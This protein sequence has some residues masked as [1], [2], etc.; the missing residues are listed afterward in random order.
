MRDFKRHNLD[1]APEGSQNI[2]E[3]VKDEYGF[4][5]NIMGEFAE[6]PQALRAYTRLDEIFSDT[7]FNPVEQ[8]II[9]LSASVAN[10]CEYCVAVHSTVAEQKQMPK[11][12]VNRIRDNETLSDDRYEALRRFTDR[13][14]R[15]RGRIAED[16][17]QD[18]LDAGFSRRQVLEL[19]VGV[20]MKTL[21][22]Y[23]N[24]IAETPLDERFSAK[25]WERSEPALA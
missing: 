21:S 9:K 19:L 11:E 17:L 15:K 18:F 3:N 7:S 12:I 5:P 23:T 1:T 10:G 8:E 14:V 16:H 2:L 13:I 4:I 25:K 22:N 24:H 6:A 20:S